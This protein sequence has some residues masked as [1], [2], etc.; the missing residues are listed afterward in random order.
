MNDS[1]SMS[2]HGLDLTEEFEGLRLTA[3]PDPATGGDPWTIG[4]GHTGADV[5][6]GLTIT[7]EEAEAFLRADIKDAEDAVKRLVRV[8]LSQGQ[9]DALTDF[10]FNCG[11]GNLAKSTMLR[12]VNDGKFEMASGEFI[13]W[14]RG[15][16]KV[17]SGLTK[18]RLAE[19]EL[20]TNANP[21]A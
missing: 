16:G 18:R 17:L 9:F 4:Y 13:R 20:F 6:P 15:A 2:E 7:Q 11:A 3:Y 14:N 1:M 5:Y 12:L 21:T 19:A 10:V 8:P